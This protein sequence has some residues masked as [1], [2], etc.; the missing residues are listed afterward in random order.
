MHIY[1]TNF[2]GNPNIG[3]YVYA[4]DSYCLV[5]KDVPEKHIKTIEK[6]LKVKT[7]R[8]T[9]AGTSMLGVFLAGNDNC[10]LV[11][12][13]VYDDE[14]E[15]LDKLKIKYKVINSHFTAL[16]NNILC[17]NEGAIINFEYEDKAAKEIEKALMIKANRTTIA[18]L[19]AVGSLGV[20]N[21]KGMIV[22]EEITAADKKLLE[23]TFDVKVHKGT[24][25]LGN[26][27]LNSGIVVNESGFVVGDTSGGPELVN[28]DESLGFI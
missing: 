24:V 15:I 11:P 9:I 25:N 2:N 17:N 27:Y 26:P 12:E 23:K 19:E 10:L 6:V 7:H 3:L 5:G 1:R 28:I 22:H 4:T 21:S 14:L 8:L 13:I 20:M 16:G 18:K